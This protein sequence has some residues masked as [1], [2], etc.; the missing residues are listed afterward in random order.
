[1]QLIIAQFLTTTKNSIL[2]LLV[3]YNKLLLNFTNI[4][5]SN[6]KKIKFKL[7]LLFY[8]IHLQ[9]EPENSGI[10]RRHF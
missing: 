3:A 9:H 1:M 8:N 4:S 2:T 6:D 10:R 7:N 5:V